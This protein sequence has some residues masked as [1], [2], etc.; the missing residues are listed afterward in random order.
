MRM[1]KVFILTAAL[2]LVGY[3]T[4]FADAVLTVVPESGP[5][6]VGQ[7]FTVGFMSPD[8]Q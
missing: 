2:M 6:T 3:S 4:A 7:T 5:L 1:A 8:R